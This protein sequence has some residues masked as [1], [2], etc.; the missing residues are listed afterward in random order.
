MRTRTERPTRRGPRALRGIL[1]VL[2]VAL[3][4]PGTLPA[5]AGQPERAEVRTLPPPGE[6]AGEAT[7]VR[8]PDGASFTFQ[9][10]S[11]EQGHVYTIWF[12]AF[13]EPE[14]CGGPCSGAVF[15]NPDLIEA[16][17]AGSLYGAGHVVGGSGR[18]TFSGHRAVGAP[19]DTDPQGAGEIGYPLLDPENAE[20]HLVLRTHGEKIPGMT[21]DQ[22]SSFNGGCRPGEPNEGQ[23][24]NLLFAKFVA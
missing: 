22:L 12:V 10:S 17:K 20:I 2:G 14:G 8:S 9:T 11:L 5:A 19:A 23:C 18:A 16:A 3:L 6:V 4:V 7:L 24:T 1:A 21:S 15:M 13:N